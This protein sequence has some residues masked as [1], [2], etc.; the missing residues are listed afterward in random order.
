[1]KIAFLFTTYGLPEQMSIWYRF[2][3]D[4]SAHHPSSFHVYI[5]PKFRPYF[6]EAPVKE[7][8]RQGQH[9]QGQHIQGQHRQEQGRQDQDRQEPD[10]QEQDRKDQ[11]RQEQDRQEQTWFQSKMVKKCIPS[12]YGGVS[13]IFIFNHLIRLAL[14]EDDTM[15]FILLSGSCLPLKRYVYLYEELYKNK[16]GNDCSYFNEG[17]VDKGMEKEGIKTTIEVKSSC[18]FILNRRHAQWVTSYT[19][20]DI[21]KQKIALRFGPE[22]WY[23]L[24][25]IKQIYRKFFLKSFQVGSTC[26]EEDFLF[27]THNTSTSTTT[28]TNWSDMNDYPPSFRVK[29]G[30]K[31]PKEYL[32]ITENEL[33]YLFHQPCFFG[34]KFLRGC[35]VVLQNENRIQLK[36]YYDQFFFSEK[37]NEK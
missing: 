27:V 1:M 22:E 28:F 34:R 12:T 32:E 31:E 35:Q 8:H 23:Y 24:T 14:Q 9:I 26:K 16:K 30:E 11:D 4:A 13:L 6:L 36:I 3:Q 20:E 7:Q 10:R 17:I 33:K 37:K 15:Y 5:H 25:T 2:F 18:W 29:I 19:D 21:A